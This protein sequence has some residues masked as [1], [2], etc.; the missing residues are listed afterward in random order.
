MTST[1][2][3]LPVLS[4]DGI[5]ALLEP[6]NDEMKTV[7]AW[8]DEQ[9]FSRPK[10]H[11]HRDFADGVMMAEL[12]HQFIPK[13]VELHNYIPANALP[14][15]KN[16]WKTLN[17]K[18]FSKLEFTLSETLIEFL[19]LSKTGAVELVLKYVYGKIMSI[20]EARA[21]QADAD[22]EA[23]HR[24]G[25]IYGGTGEGVGKDVICKVF[26]DNQDMVVYN[27]VRYLSQKIFD[28]KQSKINTQD[29]ELKELKNKVRRLETLVN[30][31]DERLCVLTM[32]LHQAQQKKSSDTKLAKISNG[33]K[34]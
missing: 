16:N 6:D 22:N 27:G 33:Q 32:E 31:K 28:E 30:L 20:L 2:V 12:I 18:V 5:D 1:S 7:L 8:I 13:I 29:Q 25:D 10:K 17:R 9:T 11:L 4:I 3:R 14:A 24:S 19:A 21:R 26:G 15:K 23:R 34:K